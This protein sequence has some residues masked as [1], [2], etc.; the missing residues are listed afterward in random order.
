MKT[1]KWLLGLLLA[2]CL[3]T[4]GPVSALAAQVSSGSEEPGVSSAQ[5]QVSEAASAKIH[6]EDIVTISGKESVA[7]A[8]VLKQGT[9]GKLALDSTGDAFENNN[10]PTLA[11]TTQFNKVTRATIHEDV[12]S[13]WYKFTVTPSDIS[14]NRVYSF[15][16]TNIPGLCDYDMYLATYNNSELGV[17]YYDLKDNALSEAFYLTFLTAG[18]YYVVIQGKDGHSD[19][20]FSDTPYALYFGDYYRTGSFPSADTGLSINFG[21]VPVG[22]TTP[23]YRGYYAYDLTN[24]TAIPD[25]AIVDHFYL[26]ADG[27]GAYWIGFMK[28]LLAAGQNVSFTQYGGIPLMDT[29]NSTLY[30]KQLWGIGGYLIASTNFVWQ[31]KVQITYT[32][33]LV[34]SNLHYL[35]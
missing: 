26:S 24:N 8:D 14:N 3:A 25:G 15:I 6:K 21:N 1:G 2:G 4:A 30:V 7:G 18:D 16:L 12:D 27:N 10:G 22:N 33:P 20:N 9:A 35:F 32:Y 23:V 28:M 31:P 19:T 11:T 17:V 29:G 34:L 13:D 5:V